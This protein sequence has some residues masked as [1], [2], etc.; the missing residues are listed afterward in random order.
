[1]IEPGMPPPEGVVPNFHNPDK[2]M[3]Y[4]SIVSNTIAI[5]V[6]TIF[7]CLRIWARRRLG[8]RLQADDSRL[9]L[10]LQHIPRPN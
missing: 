8:M 3:F 4:I 5:P 7:M 9:T 6:C 2:Q 1:M 10:Y